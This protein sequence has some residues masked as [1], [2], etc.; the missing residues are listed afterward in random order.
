MIYFHSSGP[1]PLPTDFWGRRIGP[2]EWAAS[3]R[4]NVHEPPFRKF[5]STDDRLAAVDVVPDDE[6]VEVSAG[7]E[8]DAAFGGLGHAM[9]EADVFFGLVPA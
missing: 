4:R 7:G 3:Y 5:A 2:E 8:E 1:I 6:A 9:R